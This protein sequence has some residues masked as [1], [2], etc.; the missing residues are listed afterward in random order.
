MA[1][2]SL[3]L[4]EPVEECRGCVAR[5]AIPGAGCNTAG[6]VL[7]YHDGCYRGVLIDEVDIV[8]R[9]VKLLS[10]CNVSVL[11]VFEAQSVPVCNL[12]FFALLQQTPSSAAARI[13]DPTL[14]ELIRRSRSHPLWNELLGAL[15]VSCGSN[16]VQQYCVFACIRDMF[17][18]A[19]FLPHAASVRGDGDGSL[20]VEPYCI[21]VAHALPGL[22]PVDISSRVDEAEVELLRGVVAKRV[23]EGHF[24]FHLSVLFGMRK[25]VMADVALATLPLARMQEYPARFPIRFVPAGFE[26]VVIPFRI[27]VVGRT[28]HYAYVLGIVHLTVWHC[29]TLPL[30]P[31]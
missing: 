5:N 31:V 12:V 16:T 6:D 28:R 15:L 23:P 2:Q 29:T 25:V 19:V 18:R 9:S 17:L 1:W 30:P 3:P 13:V 21:A 10:G 14:N 7:G 20:G 24:V 11:P 22:Y 26:W 4:P 27:G 8:I